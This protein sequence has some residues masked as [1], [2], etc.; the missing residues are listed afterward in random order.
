MSL[1]APVMKRSSTYSKSMRGS[2]PTTM[3][4]RLGSTSLFLKSL[5]KLSY[6][7]YRFQWQEP[8]FAFSL[9]VTSEFIL[10]TP[11]YEKQ[12]VILKA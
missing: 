3:K 7:P 10:L 11:Y 1:S 12:S 8:F 6:T 5:E 2:S 4:Y 9:V